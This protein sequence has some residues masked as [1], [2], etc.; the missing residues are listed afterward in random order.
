M[1]GDWKG[2]GGAG[3]KGFQIRPL[4]KQLKSPSLG[5]G[6]IDIVCHKSKVTLPECS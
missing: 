1:G 6:E 2:G 5:F 3:K 4:D